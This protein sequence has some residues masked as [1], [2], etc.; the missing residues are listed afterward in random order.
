MGGGRGGGVGGSPP[1]ILLG[2]IRSQAGD[3]NDTYSQS[4][5]GCN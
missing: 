3:S 4:P 1:K 5:T 2:M